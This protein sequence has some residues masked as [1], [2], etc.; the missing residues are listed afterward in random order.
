MGNKCWQRP[1]V[2]RSLILSCHQNVK[3]QYCRPQLETKIHT[4]T[5]PTT[6]INKINEN[7]DMTWNMKQ[8]VTAGVRTVN[9]LVCLVGDLCCV[10]LWSE[11]TK[12]VFVIVWSLPSP[13]HPSLTFKT[14]AAAKARPLSIIA[15]QTSLHA[16][17]G[18]AALVL[19]VHHS[20]NQGQN[21]SEHLLYFGLILRF[22]LILYSTIKY[23]YTC[24]YYI[25]LDIPR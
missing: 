19:H 20:C 15:E 17:L 7:P 25:W 14:V 23:S 10:P 8:A 5:A 6:T 3:T 12:H 13:T 9:Y 24:I 4:H 22:K 18:F 11:S 21:S 1:E 2:P 16:A